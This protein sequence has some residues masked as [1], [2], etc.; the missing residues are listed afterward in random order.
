SVIHLA[1]HAIVNERDPAKSSILLAGDHDSSGVL[2]AG[3]IANLRL[4]APLVTLA[5][6]RTAEMGSGRGSMRSLAMA[7]LVAGSSNVVATLWDLDDLTAQRTMTGFH[8]ALHS[9]LAPAFALRDAQ[10]AAIRSASPEIKAM[11]TWAAV[12]LYGSGL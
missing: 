10:I 4:H 5:G 9:G 2:Y 7:F 11:K 8:R 12:Q 3:D 1:T 6:C